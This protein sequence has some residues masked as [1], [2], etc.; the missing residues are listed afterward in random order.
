MPAT[1]ATPFGGGGDTATKRR[2]PSAEERKAFENIEIAFVAGKYDKAIT[3]AKDFVR[4]AESESL[5]TEAARLVAKAQRKKKE[6]NLARGAYL[7]LRDRY[8]KGSDEYARAEAVAEILRA[9][10][11]G[12][13]HPLVQS[14]A[15]EAG[16]TLDNDTVLK[17]AL[18]C[19]AEKRAK[20]LELRVPRLRRTRNVEQLVQQ[21]LSLAGDID[22]LRGI[23]P[24]ISPSLERQAVQTA[25]MRLK[26]V[27][28]KTIAALKEKSLHYDTILEKRSLTSS[29]RSEMLRYKAMCENLLAAE[30]A[31]LNGVDKLE[32]THN[33]PEGQSLKNE[34][35]ERCKAY[36]ELVEAFTPPE[37]PDRGGRGGTD[38][39]GRTRDGNRW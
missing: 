26:P 3:L 37:L 30:R 23:W 36:E 31:F 13:Y 7:S 39:T 12:V 9:S 33:W 2:G 14:G 20:R 17:K 19:L 1:A 22:Q 10:R 35:V 38:W 18:A 29:R 15:A 28:D 11:D 8:P 4:S 25:A 32:G 24:D 6:W 16:Q 5:K 21:F 27:S 34:N